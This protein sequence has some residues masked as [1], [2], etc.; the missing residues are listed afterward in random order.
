MKEEK[1]YGKS[2][3]AKWGNSTCPDCGKPVYAGDEVRYQYPGKSLCHSKC[4]D[5]SD[6]WVLFGGEGYGCRGWT[7]NEIVRVDT[8]KPCYSGYPEYL[9]V[10]KACEKYY[11]DDGMSFG[12]GDESGYTYTA[13]CR[14][15]TDEESAP[16]KEKI[17][18][19]KKRRAARYRLDEIKKQIYDTGEFPTKIDFPDGEIFF[20]PDASIELY[21]GGNWV[22][23]D[24]QS[25][26]YIENHGA[27]GD[28]WSLNN[29]GTGGAG[30]RG[31]RIP[32]DEKLV[33][34]LDKIRSILRE[35]K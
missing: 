10:E 24:A 13:Y 34:E 8:E 35:E 3:T 30:A 33:E 32:R 28:D 18:Q 21:G 14:P 12:V 15:A 16:L 26:W 29:I 19:Q 4:D 23:V 25:I 31:W 5:T 17:E 22:V 27:D 9:F 2:F 20:E 11:S 1:E 6:R 7:E